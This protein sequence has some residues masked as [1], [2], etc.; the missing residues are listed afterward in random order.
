[1]LVSARSCSC[2]SYNKARHG[3][4]VSWRLGAQ[5]ARR[6][7]K[8]GPP[9]TRLVELQRHVALPHAASQANGD[10]CQENH[11]ND[12]A[13]C[14]AAVVELA[15]EA[16]KAARALRRLGVGGKNEAREECN[17]IKQGAAPS[18]WN[19]MKK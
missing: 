1:M 6:C 8:K 2:I 18:R 7:D 19:E 9:S 15:M 10:H 16:G 3:A 4:K 14:Q 12:D 5:A 13:S 11:G 17:V